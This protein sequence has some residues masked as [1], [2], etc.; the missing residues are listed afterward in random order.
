MKR[1]LG[2][3]LGTNSI[4]WAIINK[5]LDKEG[6]ESL[7][8]IESAGS[9]IIPM[10]ATILGDFAKG[11]KVSQTQNRTKARSTRRMYE[12]GHLRRERLHRV[13][14]IMGYLPIGY[15]S[16]L[17]R[18]GKFLPNREPKLAWYMDEANIP[19]FL[20]Q[21][22]FQ[23][24]LDTFKKYN[25]SVIAGS[26]KIPYDW[27]IY[28]LR[29]KALYQKIQKEELAWILLN[30]NQKRGYFQLR[31]EV[32]EQVSTKTRQ[33]FDRQQV[34]DIIDTQEIYKGMKVLRVVLSD[35]TQG[36]IFK[37]QIRN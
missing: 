23:E 7:C 30:F 27:T 18:Y 29:K 20:F 21:D 22:S 34:V 19:H 12:R 28:Y 26:N 31:D 13:L 35:G 4:G 15:L 24:M 25:P 14:A 11:N 10:D 17:D 16:Q 8:G 2:L 9:R 1:I 33:Y 32:I 36:K 5:S 6:N 3:D 37:P